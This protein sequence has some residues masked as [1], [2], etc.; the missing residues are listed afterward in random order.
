MD[1]LPPLVVN[2]Q[3][4]RRPVVPDELGYWRSYNGIC[5]YCHAKH[6]GQRRSFEDL[7]DLTKWIPPRKNR[8]DRGGFSLELLQPHFREIMACLEPDQER[9]FWNLLLEERLDLTG[10]NYASRDYGLEILG[11]PNYR[12]YLGSDLY[13]AIRETTLAERGPWCVACGHLS[14]RGNALHHRR[15]SLIELLGVDLGLLEPICHRC[16]DLIERHAIGKRSLL[17]ANQFL[18]YY[19]KV[20]RR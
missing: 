5:E 17:M 6:T 11:Y 4:C 14:R 18:D 10:T 19:I 7:H 2:C 12:T 9:R 1:E 20:N 13:Q 8:Y 3:K 16:H 15:Y